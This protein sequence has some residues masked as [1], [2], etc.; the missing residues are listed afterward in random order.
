MNLLELYAKLGL[1]VSDYERGLLGAEGTAKSFGSRIGGAFKTVARVGAQALTAATGAATAF[2]GASVKAG[3][4]FDS[5]MSQVAATMGLTVDEM[6]TS[7]ETVNLAWGSFTGNLREYAQEM[8]K[9]TVFSA[10]EAADALNYMALA[11]YDVKDSMTMLPNVLNLAAAGNMDLARA[12]DMVTDTQTAFGLKM[13]EMP[14]LVDEMAKAASTGNT[15]VEQLGDAFLTVGGLARELNGGFVK[16]ANGTQKPVN[17]IQEMEIALVAMANA[18]IKGSEAGTH[19]RNMLLKLAS[20]TSDGT[21]QMEALGVSVFDTEGNMRSLSDVFGDLNERL[22]ELTQEQK[23][24]AISDLFNTRDLASAEALLHAVG[25]DWNEIGESILDAQGAAQKMADTQL[26]N[27]AGDIT[28]FKSA[29]EGAKIAL[30]DR[31]TPSL[32]KFVQF[33]SRTVSKITDAFSKRGLAGAVDVAGDAIGELLGKALDVLPRM[34]EAGGRLLR[35]VIDGIVKKLPDLASAAGRIIA[36]FAKYIIRS[37]PQIIKAAGEVMKAFANGIVEAI[38]ALQPFGKV[39]G[40]LADNIETLTTVIV[41]AVAAFMAF[42]KFGPIVDTINNAQKAFGGLHKILAANP[43]ALAMAGA[44]ALGAAVTEMFPTEAQQRAREF[45]ESLKELDERFEGIAESNEAYRLS[46]ESRL[47]AVNAAKQAADEEMGKISELRG[48]LDS[49]IGKNGEVKQSDHER[50]NQIAGE[51]MEALGIEYERNDDLIGQYINMQSE[52]DKLMVKKKAQAVL[53]ANQDAVI[54][55]SKNLEEAQINVY[56]AEQALADQRNDKIIPLQEQI[57]AKEREL[58]EAQADWPEYMDATGTSIDR[59]QQELDSLNAELQREQEALIHYKQELI[60]AQDTH[61]GYATTMAQN[62]ALMAAVLSGDADQI[63]SALDKVTSGYQTA[64]TSN[65]GSLQR[66]LETQKQTF[67][68]MER[69]VAEHGERQAGAARD[70]AAKTLLQFATEYAKAP[71]EARAAL[72]PLDDETVAAIEQAMDAMGLSTNEGMAELLEIIKGQ[73]DEF[74][75]NGASLIDGLIEGM[76]Q[77]A[78]EVNTRAEGIVLDANN[79]VRGAAGINSPSTVWAEFGRNLGEGM[80]QGIEESAD[81]VATATETMMLGAETATNESLTRQYD[82]FVQNYGNILDAATTEGAKITAQDV[83]NAADR[84]KKTV[85]EFGKRIKEEDKVAQ[86]N[87]KKNN[88]NDSALKSQD[89]K[90]T[91]ARVKE[92]AAE[93]KK[94]IAEEDK[95][96]QENKRKHQANDAALKTQSVSNAKLLVQDTT[97]EYAKMPGEAEKAIAPI[98]DKMKGTIDTA[99]S[100]KIIPSIQGVVSDS[101]T[102]FGKIVTEA[103]NAVGDLGTKMKSKI[104]LAKSQSIIPAIEGITS[105][106]KTAL[107]G[108]SK[109]FEGIG[110]NMGEALAKGIEAKKDRVARAARDLGTTASGNLKTTVEIASPSKLFMRYGEYIGEG[111]AIGIENST[112]DVEKA[113][114]EMI[115]LGTM[116]AGDIGVGG[117]RNSSGFVQNLTI[118]SPRELSAAEIARQTRAANREM[119]LQ[120]RMA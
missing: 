41:P 84:V 15:S 56:K 79:A 95:I 114:D 100:E 57:A 110:Q 13:E 68:I 38:P 24:Q 109:D 2:A 89:I 82:S 31:L 87:K 74:S 17:G 76:E 117:R 70:A 120:L 63:Q 67:D 22:G 69:A 80:S 30:S 46:E 71:A 115:N 111:L 28:L 112:P 94:R 52:I 44:V 48:Q 53:D 106:A 16:L 64:E 118:N 91:M 10:K 107:S 12:S 98:G 25:E 108:L 50:A 93:L 66:Q 102:E 101:K 119:V 61:A 97:K 35:G 14:R 47:E 90:N 116:T 103:E 73:R 51:L 3:M 81:G 77:E 5:S 60:N 19:M 9:N 34:V 37:I 8:G 65:A 105:G 1:D 40:F 20:P 72:E 104:D 11:G 99:K 39:I 49:L 59:L 78:P 54:E 113:V 43:Y 86:D 27:L 21:M 36:D 42:K 88:T 75:E 4:E 96:A 45:D 58:Q 33:G 7:V 32:R 23:I 55:A 6:Q 92:A 18:G 85:K 26:D 29:L 62:D 83:K